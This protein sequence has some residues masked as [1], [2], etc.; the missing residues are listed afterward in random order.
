MAEYLFR[1]VI[2]RHALTQQNTNC[3]KKF[4]QI[5]WEHQIIFHKK[6]EQLSRFKAK[7]SE[8]KSVRFGGTIWVFQWLFGD[9]LINF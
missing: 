4:K 8:I 7:T 2:E 9:L 6:R 3:W 5:Y 1:I